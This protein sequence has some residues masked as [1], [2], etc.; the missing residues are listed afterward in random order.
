MEA[1][2]RGEEGQTGE[3]VRIRKREEK[4]IGMAEQA[5]RAGKYQRRTHSEIPK[6]LWL[7]I[8]VKVKMSEKAK[9]SELVVFSSFLKFKDWK[10]TN[11]NGN[12][13]FAANSPDLSSMGN[14]RVQIPLFFNFC[15]TKCWSYI[16][17]YVIFVTDWKFLYIQK[18]LSLSGKVSQSLIHV[19][20]ARA[21]SL[22]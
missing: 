14:V 6:K 20:C 12:F 10:L 13:R 5:T 11:R 9:Q 21:D 3:N 16:F 22:F 7:E 1:L 17:L 18:T 2:G 15:L 19:K 8:K 4:C